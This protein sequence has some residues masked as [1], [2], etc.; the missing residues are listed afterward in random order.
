MEQDNTRTKKDTMI[1]HDAEKIEL[2]YTRKV[3]GGIRMEQEET[4]KKPERT[5]KDQE[6]TMVEQTKGYKD[7]EKRHKE[8]S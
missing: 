3:Q 7:K 2:R 4:R 8:G 1:D 6:R 5:G